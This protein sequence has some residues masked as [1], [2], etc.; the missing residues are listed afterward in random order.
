VKALPSSKP[1]TAG[2]P[3]RMVRSTPVPGNGI[4]P[5]SAAAAHRG[6]DVNEGYSTGLTPEARAAIREKATDA[7]KII[8]AADRGARGE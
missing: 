1:A 8:A 4:A 3:N 2:D 5:A 6:F 7:D